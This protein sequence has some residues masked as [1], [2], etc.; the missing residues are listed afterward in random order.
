MKCAGECERTLS[1]P[2]QT[3][4]Q[5][6]PASQLRPSSSIGRVKSLEQTAEIK[7]L[8]K[9]AGD[10]VCSSLCLSQTNTN[11]LLSSMALL[12]FHF[13]FGKLH[14]SAPI[15]C[16]AHGHPPV[17]ALIIPQHGKMYSSGKVRYGHA[18]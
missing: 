5:L 12:A 8:E 9:L 11:S 16:D 10:H 15:Q 14:Y 6:S 7:D 17:L 18:H 13:S 2:L 4:H 1:F 3:A